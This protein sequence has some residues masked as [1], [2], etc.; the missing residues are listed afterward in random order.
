MAELVALPLTSSTLATLQQRVPVP[1]YDRARLR[2][3]IVHI[4][5][6]GFHRSHLATYI[7]D[8]CTQGNRDWSIVG[9]GVLAA[10]SAMAEALAAQDHLYSL[11]VRSTDESSVTIIGSIVDYLHAHPDPQPLIDRIAHP[12]TVIVSLTITE[13]G[14]PIDDA[15]GRYNEDSAAGG[16]GST[17]AVLAAGLARRRQQG[18]DPVTIVSCDNLMANGLAA[19][20]ATLGEADRVDPSL[21]SWI[22]RNVAFPNSMVDRITPAT[23][24]DDRIWLAAE[25]GIQDRWPVV[26]EPF[27]QWVIEDQFAGEAPPLTGLGVLVTSDVE[28]YERLKLRLL[29]AGHSCLAYLAALLEIERVDQAMAEPELHAFVTAFL[30]EAGLALPPVEGIDVDEYKVSLVTRFA[31][32]AIGDQISRLCLDGSAKFPKFLIPTI[33]TLHDANNSTGLAAL[34]LAGWCQYLT[35][36]AESGRSIALSPDPMLEVARQHAEASLTDPRAF[37]KF[38]EVFSDAV[39]EHPAF[40][41]AFERS[42]SLIRSQGVRSAIDTILVSRGTT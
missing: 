35:G 8:L 20:E 23:T 30:D 4:G 21:T 15:T 25:R 32:A 31:N 3:S 37:L 1:T 12:D 14:Y 17:F 39:A 29:N 27:R 26:A 36:R 34:A 38:P 16:P 42:L 28:P 11:I 7:D 2:R 5:V 10:D 41:D 13:G 9:T 22:E 33:E 40:S 24:D 19:K 6:G 18:M